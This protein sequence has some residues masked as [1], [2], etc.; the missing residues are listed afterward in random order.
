MAQ[1]KAIEIQ[2]PAGVL[3][4]RLAE[5]EQT[6]LGVLMCHPHPLHQGTMNNKV[7]TTV[8][9]TAASLGLPSLRFNFRGVGASDG[10]H[11]HGKGEQ[12]DVLAALDYVLNTLG[13]EKVIMAGFSFGAG[14][15]CL[16]ACR[17]PEKLAALVLLAPAVHHFDAPNTLPN[18]F[19]T[20]VYMG[21]GDEVVPFDEVDNW[22]SLVIPTPHFRVFADGSHF[23]HGRLTDL[24]ASLKE[25]LA[26]LLEHL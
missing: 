19:E 6:Q 13:W 15:A 1:E 24:K 5:A 3:E 25:D 9:R 16:A 20:F 10:Q 2:G 17:A 7:V 11:D 23:F 12:E 14:M 21:D 26:P 8:T 22:A 4:G 18:Q